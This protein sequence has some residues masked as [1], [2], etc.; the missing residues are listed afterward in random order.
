MSPFSASAYSI[1]DSVGARSQLE[2]REKDG[3]IIKSDVTCYG[4]V[5]SF[6]LLSR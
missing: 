1:I 3:S 4:I 2:G 6:S 5:E